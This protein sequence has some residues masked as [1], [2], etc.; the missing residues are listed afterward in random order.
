MSAIRHSH[1][2][3]AIVVFFALTIAAAP[4]SALHAQRPAGH[5]L[6][7]VDT[8]AYLRIADIR[9]LVSRFRETALGRIAREQQVR[10]LVAQLYGSANDAFQKVED[11]V[12]LTLPELLSLPR[13]ELTVALVP[14]EDKHPVPVLLVDVSQQQDRVRTL[15]DH[16]D[17]LLQ[18]RGGK[19]STATVDGIEVILLEFSGRRQRQ[20]VQLQKN[21]TLVLTGDLE[22][23][24]QV[25]AKWSGDRTL[26]PLADNDSFSTVMSRTQSA[27]DEPPQIEWF[28]DPISL[29]KAVGRG[30]AAAQTGLALLPGLGLDGLK[31]VGGSITLVTEDFESLSRAHILIDGPR[32]GV[33]AMLALQSGDPTPEAWVPEDVATY[34]TMYWDVQRTYQEVQSLF[35]SLRGEGALKRAIDRRISDQLGVDFEQDLLPAMEGRFSHATWFEP[36][37]RIGSQAW[38]IGA[39]L[40]DAEQ[41]QQTLDKIAD[42]VGPFLTEESHAGTKYYRYTPPSLAPDDESTEKQR[43]SPRRQFRPCFAVVGQYLLVADRPSFLQRTITTRTDSTKSLSEQLDFKL[44]S[45]KLLRQSG[46]NQPSLLVFQRP[47][48]GMRSLYDMAASEQIRQRLAKAAENNRVFGMLHQTL[49]DNPLPPFSVIKKHLAPTGGILTNDMTGIHYTE[50]SL[51]RK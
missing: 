41:F 19:R 46:A 24:R 27:R 18:D 13:G 39:R 30:N 25:L 12:G 11:R 33:L 7:P 14:R 21:S 49:E 9:D 36:P 3:A 1:G 15:I 6:L 28:V 43:E 44:V 23:A 22:V 38:L 5:R 50:F 26:A 48:K 4:S 32:S 40:T 37:A 2:N 16:V 35:D 47:E 20:L 29:V 45:S 51:R 10:P 17:A 42:Q 8:V 34:M 31:G